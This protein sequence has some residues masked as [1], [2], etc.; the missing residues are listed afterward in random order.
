MA[1]VSGKVERE[2][3]VE[4]DPARETV[5]ALALRE[6]VT[7]VVRH[8]GART[9]RISLE[10]TGEETR[11]EVR[12]DGRGGSTPEGIGLAS[13]R[14]RIEGLGGSLERGVET[15]TSL[16]IVLPRREAPARD[17]KERSA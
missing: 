12:D 3:T 5:L 15:G 16:R 8:A 11:L 2:L 9:C 4:L 13:M 14:E 1:S 7:N 17:L 10:Q 6:A